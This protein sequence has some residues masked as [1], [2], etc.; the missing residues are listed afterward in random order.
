VW[1]RDG[2]A[3]RRAGREAFAN[4]CERRKALIPIPLAAIL[5]RNDARG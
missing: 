3:E 5:S 4:G 2:G 1:M